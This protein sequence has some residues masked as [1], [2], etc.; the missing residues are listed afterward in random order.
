MRGVALTTL[1]EMTRV[2]NVTIEGL[3][4]ATEDDL[5]SVSTFKVA[6]GTGKE[7]CR[8]VLLITC[9]WWSRLNQNLS[10]MPLSF[11]IGAGDQAQYYIG[12]R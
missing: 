8:D 5:A 7:G 10:S 6:A 11:G 3:F 12:Q 9:S 2:W 4:A 1:D